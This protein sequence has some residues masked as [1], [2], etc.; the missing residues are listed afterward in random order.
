MQRPWW[1]GKGPR[2]GRRSRRQSAGCL[3]SLCYTQQ[4]SALA[5]TPPP[6]ET[7]ATTGCS[8][9]VSAAVCKALSH[10]RCITRCQR[11]RVHGHRS[12]PLLHLCHLIH[13]AGSLRWQGEGLCVPLT[14][15]KSRDGILQRCF[16]QPIDC[17]LLRS[18]TLFTPHQCHSAASCPAR[19]WLALTLPLQ[20]AASPAHL[21]HTLPL[22][23]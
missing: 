5:T 20:H 10:R 1:R 2:E 21:V 15:C 16:S 13:R 9:A 22:P 6:T 14:S 8:C 11:R 4:G 3:V 17:L 23:V 12:H 18:T 19:V 7:D